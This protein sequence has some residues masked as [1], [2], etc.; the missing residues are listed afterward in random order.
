L[1]AK[2]ARLSPASNIEKT[3]ILDIGILVAA[4]DQGVVHRAVCGT[5]MRNRLKA[6]LSFLVV[7]LPYAGAQ[8][9]PV[10]RMGLALTL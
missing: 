8:L 3:D 10:C 1:A 2:N 5:G 9:A 4:G 6:M 7:D